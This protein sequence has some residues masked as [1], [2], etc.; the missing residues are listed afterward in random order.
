L[1]SGVVKPPRRLDSTANL[2]NRAR[3]KYLRPSIGIDELDHDF[4]I[5][6]IEMPV[7][8]R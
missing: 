1:R 5:S 8:K 4:I 3:P 2:S 6:N 7:E